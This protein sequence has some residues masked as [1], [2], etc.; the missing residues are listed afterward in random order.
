M[1]ECSRDC[2][3]SQTNRKMVVPA[4]H[5]Q[6]WPA[7]LEDQPSAPVKCRQ[8]CLACFL[9]HVPDYGFKPKTDESER[10]FQVLTVNRNWLIKAKSLDWPLPVGAR[11]LCPVVANSHWLKFW[12]AFSC[13]QTHIDWI[14]RCVSNLALWLC[15][16]S[17]V[18]QIKWVFEFGCW[19]QIMA[20]SGATPVSYQTEFSLQGLQCFVEMLTAMFPSENEQKLHG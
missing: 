18:A 11:F 15:R 20:A 8:A 7:K 1:V 12:I 6:L 17:D 16:E 9:S 14:L 4:W 2:K 19:S 10:R 3:T 5:V 13:R